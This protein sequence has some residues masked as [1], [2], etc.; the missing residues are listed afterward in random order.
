MYEEQRDPD[1]P[2]AN[3]TDMITVNI[4]PVNDPPLIFLF[5]NGQS[6]LHDDPTE[7]ITVCLTAWQYHSGLFDILYREYWTIIGFFGDFSA[8]YIRYLALYLFH[9]HLIS[10]LEGFAKPHGLFQVLL[11]AKNDFNVESWSN[12]WTAILGAYDVEGT[13]S[14]YFQLSETSVANLT[15][16]NKD[17][18]IPSLF[19]DCGQVCRNRIITIGYQNFIRHW[20]T[21]RLTVPVLSNILLKNII[22][23]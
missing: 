20:N 4:E 6:I 17:R 12:P 9:N 21:N 22:V 11:E 13:D 18:G 7:P 23:F 14:L 16:S 19:R 5:H 10:N 2:P 15:L 1:I 8:N 3:A